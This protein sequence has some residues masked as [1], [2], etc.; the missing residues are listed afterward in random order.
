[1]ARKMWAVK[2]GEGGGIHHQPPLRGESL[3]YIWSLC[4]PRSKK[5]KQGQKK[6]KGNCGRRRG[7]AERIARK[8]GTDGARRPKNKKLNRRPPER[9]R[10]GDGMKLEGK[11]AGVQRTGGGDAGGGSKGGNFRGL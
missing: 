4:R 1:M 9:R 8:G 6:G 5:I 10:R 3:P 7:S 2:A 11:K